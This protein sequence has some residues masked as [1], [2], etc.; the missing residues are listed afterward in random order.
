MNPLK[1]IHHLHFNLA[2]N[3]ALAKVYRKIESFIAKNDFSKL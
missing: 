1:L 3:S 2:G